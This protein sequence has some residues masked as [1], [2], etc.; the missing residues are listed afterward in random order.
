MEV[1]LDF[2]ESDSRLN[3][4]LSEMGAVY[5]IVVKRGWDAE[6]EVGDVLYWGP[7]PNGVGMSVPNYDEKYEPGSIAGQV[8]PAPR[9][10]STT[11]RL[12]GESKNWRR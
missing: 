1:A 12:E 7:A 6:L 11:F 2:A 5:H 4:D 10:S 9:R 8:T 3:D